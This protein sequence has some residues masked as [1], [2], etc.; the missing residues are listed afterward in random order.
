MCL[1][2]WAQ[3]KYNYSNV[4]SPRFRRELPTSKVAGGIFMGLNSSQLEGTLSVML[5]RM[6]LRIQARMK[7]YAI[8]PVSL[9]SSG[10]HRSFLSKIINFRSLSSPVL[11]NGNSCSQMFK[12]TALII[13]W[14][15]PA[16]SGFSEGELDAAK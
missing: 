7:Q 6:T 3:I 1:I 16:L 8:R 12:E 10:G 11:R 15:Y 2:V 13:F 9:L 4:T 14:E 5:S